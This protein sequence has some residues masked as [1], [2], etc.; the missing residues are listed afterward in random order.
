MTDKEVLKIRKD[1]PWFKNNRDIIYLDSCATTLKNKSMVQAIEN[2]YFNWCTNTHNNDSLFAYETTKMINESR[3]VVADLL[4]VQ[5]KE[6]IFTSGATE[7]LNLIANGL[8]DL[9]K[10]GDEILLT[11][12]EHSSNLLP[13]RVVANEV[14]AKLV[15]ASTNGFPTEDDFIKKI[16]K[17]TKIITFCNVSNILGYEL[18]FVNIAKRAKAI[19]PEIIVVIDATQAIP[20]NKYNIGDAN[21]DFLAFSGHKMTGPTGIGVCYI[22]SKWLEKIKPLKYGGGMNS[23]MEE[24]YFTYAAAP[25]K[26][27]GGTLNIAGIIGLGITVKYLNNIGWD[28]I[29]QHQLELKQYINEQFKD[30]PNLEFYNPQAPYPIAFFNMKGCSSQDLAGYLGN[31]KIIVRSGLSCAKLSKEITH[32]DEAV[33]VSCYFYTTRKDIDKLVTALKEYRKGD[34][35]KHVI[36]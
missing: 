34:E 29:H 7:S 8:K 2:Y 11:Y 27:E 5:F 15:Y 1:F 24:D 23:V 26:F 18:D 35:L 4:N 13:W 22:N 20:H 31:K 36:F 21:I 25:D 12:N 28:K 6:T 10:K 17:R 30:I 9:L 14:G 33:R 19:N 32:I 16:T 3:Q